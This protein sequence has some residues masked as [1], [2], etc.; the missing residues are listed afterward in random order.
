[1]FL[2]IGNQCSRYYSFFYYLSD[3]LL[4]S[5]STAQAGQP[6]GQE[7]A[8]EFLNGLGK[9]P[10]KKVGKGVD[11]DIYKHYPQKGRLTLVDYFGTEGL[12]YEEALPNMKWNLSNDTSTVCGYVCKKATTSFR[13]RSYT[14]WYTREIPVSDGPWK[15]NGLPGLILK[16]IDGQ[17]FFSFECT[18]IERS[19]E[20]KL[21]E[22]KYMTR[23][24]LSRME[25][26][27]AIQRYLENPG[28]Y[29]SG[30]PIMAETS[31]LPAN[32]YKKRPY[33]PIE[34]TDE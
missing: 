7:G 15:F 3:S 22:K 14:V 32:A 30:S 17:G 10:A 19:K 4:S 13:G 33:N 25:Y 9:L 18:A 21:I 26:N 31:P 23:R 11:F 2:Q 28:A 6:L 29:M 5:I 20:I 24:K 1:M 27:K 16:A 34:R 8:Q 12:E